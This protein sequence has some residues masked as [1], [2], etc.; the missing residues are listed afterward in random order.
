MLL[1]PWL[2]RPRPRSEVSSCLLCRFRAV[3]SACRMNMSPEVCTDECLV[4]THESS[5]GLGPL[6]CV[7]TRASLGSVLAERATNKNWTTV[8]PERK[9]GGSV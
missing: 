6:S 4:K 1:M 7:I 8:W 5:Y 3:N 2:W 9:T